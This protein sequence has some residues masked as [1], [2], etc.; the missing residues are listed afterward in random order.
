MPSGRSSGPSQHAQTEYPDR[1]REDAAARPSLESAHVRRSR[2]LRVKSPDAQTIVCDIDGTG[3]IEVVATYNRPS[4]H[5]ALIQ[6][7]RCRGGSDIRARHGATTR[8]RTVMCR[9]H[10]NTGNRMMNA[11]RARRL[12]VSL[13]LL[14]WATLGSAA[15]AKAQTPRAGSRPTPDGLWTPATDQ[16]LQPAERRSDLAGPYA[17]AQLNRA[18]LGQLLARAPSE[19]SPT[20]ATEPQV[21]VSLPMPDGTFGRFR[22][23]ES[24]LLGAEL[25]ARY[26]EIR[27][28]AGVGLTDRTATARLDVTP[29]GFHAM[30]MAGERLV[31]VDPYAVGDL[32]N[33]VSYERTSRRGPRA[34]FVDDVIGATDAQRLYNQLPLVNGS[35]LRTYRVVI[36][37]TGEYTTAAG[38]TANAMSAI[39]TM[40]NRINGIYRQELSV[41]LSWVNALIYQ[42]GIND[43]FTN[44]NIDRLLDE[45]QFVV[46]GTIGTANYDMAHVLSF[47]DIGGKA[48]LGSVCVNTGKA[49]GASGS[50]TPFADV[51]WVDYV[52]HEIGHQ[53]GANHTFNTAGNTVASPC[54]PHRSAAHAYEVGAGKSI[55]SY[56]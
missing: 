6:R 34:P 41:Q 30:I 42:D 14:I 24:P 21:V 50:S 56:A 51:F 10:S 5:M 9:H 11:R 49:R 16:I 25:A 37:T 43:P 17:V 35:V 28:Y 26:P 48:Q 38:G 29:L 27:T 7:W 22:V 1:G 36:S 47:A 20:R 13:A 44:E 31:Y 40:L 32:V 2:E 8:E 52:A 33:H 55:M 18:A 15:A 23:E 54:G 46:N 12:L 53:F 4:N 39:T 45:N 19:T 3:P